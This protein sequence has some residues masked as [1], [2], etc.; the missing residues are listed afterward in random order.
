MRNTCNFFRGNL[1][2][3]GTGHT[4]GLDV[5]MNKDC[6]ILDVESVKMG[7]ELIKMRLQSNGNFCKYDNKPAGS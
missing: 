1:R 6:S 5:V 3:T 4:E 7:T 2:G